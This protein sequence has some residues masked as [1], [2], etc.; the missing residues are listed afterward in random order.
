MNPSPHY[1]DVYTHLKK[2]EK[3]LKEL[4]SVDDKYLH[5]VQHIRPDESAT[6]V[7]LNHE[8][9]QLLYSSYN[10]LHYTLRQGITYVI[11]QESERCE[12]CT[13]VRVHADGLECR[14]HCSVAESCINKVDALL[15]YRAEMA[16][17]PVDSPAK[18]QRPPATKSYAWN[19][20]Y[21]SSSSSRSTRRRARH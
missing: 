12:P 18:R 14:L 19:A 17:M 21:P 3:G 10:E 5:I 20:T 11:E 2:L 6:R 1:K 9:L 7:E 4:Q 13:L 8:Q 16:S 15:A